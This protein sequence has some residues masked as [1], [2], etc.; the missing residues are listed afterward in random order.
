MRVIEKATRLFKWAIIAYILCIAGMLCSC[1]SV[2]YVDRTVV[3]TDTIYKSKIQKDSIKVLDSVYVKEYTKGDTVFLTTTKY[4]YRDKLVLKSDTIYKSK[5]DT[6][7][8]EKTIVKERKATKWKAL[9]LLLA[10]ILILVIVATGY[11][12]KKDR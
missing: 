2:E 9:S 3:R 6:C 8:V 1:K 5:T 4:K 10:F 12:Y 11:V 7:Y